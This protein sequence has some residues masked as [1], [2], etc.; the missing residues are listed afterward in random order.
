MPFVKKNTPHIFLLIGLFCFKFGHSNEPGTN[1]YKDSLRAAE[2]FELAWEYRDHNP[3]SSL[4]FAEAAL[5][6]AERNRLDQLRAYCHSLMGNYYSLH[7]EYEQ[8]EFHLAK[9]IQIRLGNQDSVDIASG[10]NNLALLHNQLEQYDSAIYLF[11]KGLE[12][13]QGARALQTRSAI[14]NGLSMSLLSLRRFEEAEKYLL[15]AIQVAEKSADSP[16]LAKRYHNMGKFYQEVERYNLALEYYQKAFSIYEVFGNTRGLVDIIVNE[17]AVK[18]LQGDYKAAI[19]KLEWGEELSE[20]YELQYKRATLY[21]D[22]GYAYLMDGQENRA[23]ATLQKGVDLALQLEKPLA[24]VQTALNLMRLRIARHNYQEV[25][26]YLPRIKEAISKYRIDRYLPDYYSILAQAYS[27]IGEYKNAFEVQVKY[28]YVRDSL[29][30]I[31]DQAQIFLEENERMKRDEKILRKQN[32]LQ[33]SQL[34][35]QQAENDRQTYLILLLALGGTMSIGFLLMRNRAIRAKAK[36]TEEKKKSEEKLMRVLR[37]VDVQLLETQIEANNATSF[38]IGQNLH[39][40]LGSK[41]AV[42]Q[43][44]I[45]GIRKKVASGDPEISRRFDKVEEWLEESCEDLRNIS[46]DLQDRELKRRGLEQEI[47]LYTRL[48]NEAE[49]LRVHFIPANLPESLS[50]GTQKEMAAITR[51]LIENV[52]RHAKAEDVTIRL[53]HEPEKLTLTVEDNGQGFDTD[54][55]LNRGGRGLGNAKLRAEKLGGEFSILSKP[56]LGT[57]AI[58]EIP[59]NNQ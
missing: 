33:E 37:Q 57:K 25:L 4:L 55:T 16:S 24:F 22:L 50:E 20:S 48:I 46:H 42:V 8:A 31:V 5:Q 58:L 43:T 13:A 23:A 14:L 38:R 17:G 36:V 47:E 30:E 15:E 1:A 51:L 40:N 28:Q 19:K 53:V 3:D 49:G 10:Y 35:Q 6:I 39:D 11:R 12:F 9:S 52:L 27:G 21:N 56:G 44:S 54:I 2:L 45:E 34:L 59:L 41:L 29:D 26:D 18:L 32:E 7:E